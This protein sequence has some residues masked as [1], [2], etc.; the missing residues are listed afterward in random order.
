MPENGTELNVQLQVTYHTYS[1]TYTD[2]YSFNRTCFLQTQRKKERDTR[3]DTQIQKQKTQTDK[4][5]IKRLQNKTIVTK[6]T[7][8]TLLKNKQTKITIIII[9]RRRNETKIDGKNGEKQKI[10]LHLFV[11]LSKIAFVDIIVPYL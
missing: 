5:T 4:Q 1:H 7:T 6:N 10:P 9:K 3:E 2:M 8:N 11:V